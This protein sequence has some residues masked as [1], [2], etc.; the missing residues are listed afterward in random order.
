MRYGRLEGCS[1]S[2]SEIPWTTTGHLADPILDGSSLKV[3]TDSKLLGF[4]FKP[5]ELASESLIA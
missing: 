4:T 3:F 1:F 2:Q 5:Q